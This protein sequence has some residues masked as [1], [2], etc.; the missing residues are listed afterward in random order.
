MGCL[1]AGHH[2]VDLAETWQVMD[3]LCFQL[4]IMMD[5]HITQRHKMDLKYSGL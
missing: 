1:E 2:R 5:L 3:T 4:I